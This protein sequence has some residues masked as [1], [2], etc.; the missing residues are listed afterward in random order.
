MLRCE[1]VGGQGSTLPARQSASVT[2]TMLLTQP[3]QPIREQ[4]YVE[5]DETSNTNNRVHCVAECGP[6][7]CVPVSLLQGSLLQLWLCRVMP[8]QSRPPFLGGGAEQ[9]LFL[10]LT[11]PPH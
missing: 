2:S 3:E 11:P 4:T 5:L 7:V 9:V 6:P 10:R 8:S 1:Q